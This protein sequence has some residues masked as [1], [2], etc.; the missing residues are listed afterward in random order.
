MYYEVYVDILFVEN[1]WMNAMLLLLTAWADQAP[2]KKRRIVAAAALGSLGACMLTIASA[3]LSGMGYFIGGLILAAGMVGIAFPGRRHFGFRMFSLYA[4]CFVLN[5]ILR[6]LEQFHRLN[7]IWFAVF[8]SISVLF[9]TAAERLLKS[10]RRQRERNCSV[11]LH[12]GAC[13]M[14]VEALYDT[15]NSL[16]DPISGRPVSIMAGKLLERLLRESG[17]ENLPRLIPYHTISQK[18]ILEAYV[19]DG[20]EVFGTDKIRHAENIMV[21]RMPEES[22][23]YQLILHRDLLSS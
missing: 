4:E 21:A 11:V 10:R 9:L 19:L 20:M 22:G 7:G 3:W 14:D 1:L 8:S 2:V 13:R 12:H 6:Y 18:G 5:G 16:Y 17:K 23:Q 15:G